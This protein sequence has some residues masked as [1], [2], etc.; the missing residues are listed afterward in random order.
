MTTKGL[1]SEKFTR[2]GFLKGVVGGVA[3]LTGLA[4]WP[5]LGMTQPPILIG[6]PLSQAFLYGWNARSNLLM[7]IDEINARGGVD[8]GGVKRR[9][10]L[11]VI[12]TRDLEPGVPVAEAL[13]AV[14]KL[15]LDKKVDVIL[16]G[17]VRS[18]AAL[19]AQSLLAK[20]KKV[21]ILTTGVLSPAYHRNIAANYDK[22][23]SFKYMFRITSEVVELSR[24]ALA[25]FEEVRKKF[26][27]DTVFI[28]VQDVAHA[29]G[30]GTLMLESLSKAG[31]KVLGTEIFPTGASD[32]SV[33]LLKAKAAGAKLLFVWMDHPETW[34]LAKQWVDLKIPALIISGINSF[35]EQPG[36]WKASEGQIAFLIASTINAG[37]TFS[38]ATPLTPR[39]FETHKKVWGVE[40]EG[41]GAST[42][43]Q[44]VYVLADAIERAGSLDPDALV[45]ALEKTDIPATIPAG[46]K[47]EDISARD[48]SVIGRVRFDPKSHQV[49]PSGDPK[50]GVV[51][52]WH[53]WLDGKRVTVWPPKIAVGEIQLPPFLR[54]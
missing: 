30:I 27:L 24:Q 26:K 45:A 7:A 2:R 16:G 48:V 41:Y 47:P 6:A 13:L 4:L 20:H 52:N 42:S 19:A 21:S 43:Y 39:Y 22:D 25:L 28:M 33:S 1:K 35:L 49:I 46:K 17:P 14:E 50:E 34:I 23:P 10:Q 15:I 9:F 36:S 53:Q 40:P 31:F 11:E 51:G 29:R 44:A 5:S 12:E 32:Y 3:G 38:N 8:V 18:E 54:P 37:N